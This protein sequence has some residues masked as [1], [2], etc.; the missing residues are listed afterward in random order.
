MMQGQ[1]RPVRQVDTSSAALQEQER[2]P[3]FQ[4]DFVEAPVVDENCMLG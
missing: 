2:R 3:Y 4:D 1:K